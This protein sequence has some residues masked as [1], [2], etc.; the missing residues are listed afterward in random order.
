M[1]DKEILKKAIEKANT[2]YLE[3][4]KITWGWSDDITEE[5]VQDRGTKIIFSHAFAKA[6][7][8]EGFVCSD[9]GKP[10]SEKHTGLGQ[11]KYIKFAW[12]HHLQQMV[13]CEN[14]IKYL[15]QFL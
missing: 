7:W 15:E 5:I 3:G 12:Q 9:C 13:I 14:R 2:A 4:S 6:F 8:G 10:L 1:T 11:H